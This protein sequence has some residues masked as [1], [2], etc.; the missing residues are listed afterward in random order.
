MLA[1]IQDRDEK[2]CCGC[3]A[4]EQICPKRAISMH[5]NAEGFLYPVLDEVSCI[6][7]GLCE[8]VCPMM[9]RPEGERIRA[10]Y[11]V[12]HKK[13][14]IL[15]ASSS[16]GVFRL[17][18]DEV[19]QD[20]G[21]VVG[22]VWNDEYQ[23]VLRIAHSLEE[24][25]P[26]QGS[27]YVSSD[28][29]TVFSQVK[30]LLEANESV[31]FTGTPCQCAGLIRFLRKPYDKLLTADFLCHG[32]PSQIVFAS[33]LDHIR[34]RRRIPKITSFQFRDK[35]KR[36][37]GHVSSYTWEKGG[38]THKKYMVGMTDPYDY[39]FLNGYF[40]RYSCYECPFRG[41]MHF[42][43]FTF[44]D[45]WGVE[46]YHQMDSEKGVSA[47]SLNSEKAIQYSQR[48]RKNAVWIE[49]AAEQVAVDNPALLHDH[50][51]NV[52]TLR[53]KI[54][55]EIK[56]NGWASVERKYLHA[57]NRLVKQIWY[58]LP[59]SVTKGIKKIVKRGKM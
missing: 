30:Q 20:G 29:N 38:K 44:C 52:P 21:Y 25:S 2:K 10:V 54:Y 31:L 57:R 50:A 15:K 36:G 7:C 5:K 12:Q 58:S 3:R 11:A 42:T 27:K 39:G 4:C 41:D 16:G 48:L 47:I 28:T 22:C 19:I 17:L 51:E 18:A 43:D 59:I 35:S 9:N 34:A 40:N 37:W 6:K 33:Y 14:D 8:N 26:M 45:Y 46:R 53:A 1:Y 32:I 24:L 56:N 49:T 23:P 13:E 55:G